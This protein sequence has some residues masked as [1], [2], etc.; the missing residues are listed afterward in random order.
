ML[1]GAIAYY[2]LLS[3]EPLLI[4]SVI[5]L[6]HL[7]DKADLFDALGRY[8]ELSLPGPGVM[9]AGTTTSSPSPAR[10]VASAP[11]ATRGAW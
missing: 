7:V 3:M 5:A 6:S 9:T 2:A 11:R 8:L 4:L 1:A 10:A